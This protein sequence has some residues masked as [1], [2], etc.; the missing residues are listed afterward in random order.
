M[1]QRLRRILH[2]THL[3][4]HGLRKIEQFD[5]Y[6]A[7]RLRD[8]QPSTMDR[9]GE[10][11][12]GVAHI[13]GLPPCGA[14]FRHQI[15]GDIKESTPPAQHRIERLRPVGKAPFAPFCIEGVQLGLAGPECHRL[16]WI[17]HRDALA[18]LLF[19][20]PVHV[21]RRDAERRRQLLGALARCKAPCDF[22]ALFKLQVFR[23]PR[24]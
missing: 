3:T 13:L 6:S 4:A 12:S 5:E 15:A 14:E 20:E 11:Q 1:T 9:L 23:W 16:A 18:R 19:R 24:H 17:A 8:L 22:D 21:A 7:V 10:G 2:P